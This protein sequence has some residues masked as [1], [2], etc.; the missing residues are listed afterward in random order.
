MV[1]GRSTNDWLIEPPAGPEEDCR[2]CE[3]S[4][5]IQGTWGALGLLD[6]RVASLLS[7]TVQTDRIPLWVAPKAVAAERDPEAGRSTIS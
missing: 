2:H 6:R 4:E 3:R 5:A 7:M 1:I